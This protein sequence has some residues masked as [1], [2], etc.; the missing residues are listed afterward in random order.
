MQMQA[1]KGKNCPTKHKHFFTSL[2]LQRLRPA[3][4]KSLLPETNLKQ[5]Y[6]SSTWELF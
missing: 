3:A 6:F 2:H 4:A 5:Q 1:E